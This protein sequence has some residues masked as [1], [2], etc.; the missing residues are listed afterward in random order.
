MFRVD[1]QQLKAAL[2]PSPTA[3]LLQLGEALPRAAARLYSH[4]I[5]QVHSATSILKASIG[6]VEDY[7]HQLAFLANLQAR[8]LVWLP[9]SLLMTCLLY[10]ANFRV[11]STNIQAA[12]LYRGMGWLLGVPFLLDSCI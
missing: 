9:L 10:G 7:V 1:A 6:S 8:H 2:L 11:A 3:L 12:E 4:F 5:K